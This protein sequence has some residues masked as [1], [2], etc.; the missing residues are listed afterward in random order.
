MNLPNPHLPFCFRCLSHQPL[1]LL[2]CTKS[3]PISPRPACD[4]VI[5][6]RR[7]L[8]QAMGPI[9]A[10]CGLWDGP[11]LKACKCTIAAWL[12]C[13]NLVCSCGARPLLACCFASLLLFPS[14]CSMVSMSRACHQH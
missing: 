4:A 8:G 13:S 10:V 11:S 1:T 2:Y 3:Q 12:P 5:E 6:S 7:H 14:S 9:E